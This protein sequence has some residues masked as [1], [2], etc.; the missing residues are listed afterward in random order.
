MIKYSLFPI[1]KDQFVPEV[2]SNPHNEPLKSVLSQ[3]YFK[4]ELAKMQ[5]EKIWPP[6]RVSPEFRDSS[7]NN[8]GPEKKNLF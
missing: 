6:C 7:S 5:K 2:I 8:T 4:K 3:K 1:T